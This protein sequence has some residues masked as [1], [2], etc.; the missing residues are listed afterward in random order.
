M[1]T[2]SIAD[3]NQPFWAKYLPSKIVSSWIRRYSAT[4]S[5]FPTISVSPLLS[6]WARKK[7]VLLRHIVTEDFQTAVIAEPV[8]NQLSDIR[9]CAE[10]LREKEV[11]GHI[12]C[13]IHH[14]TKDHEAHVELMTVSVKERYR[15]KGIGAVMIATAIDIAEKLSLP[16]KLDDMATAVPSFVYECR[17]E[18]KKNPVFEKIITYFNK[19][20]AEKNIYTSMGF[21]HAS[22]SF[23][24]QLPHPT[25]LNFKPML[26][27]VEAP[28]LAENRQPNFMSQKRRH[29]I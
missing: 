14:E 27:S 12:I 19:Q 21:S 4:P 17:D 6:D 10:S 29:S 3:L 15:G 24:S 13:R 9:I 26:K 2:L 18:D 7:G 20:S 8:F 25:I 11:V 1:P 22:G 28:T 23:A 5:T 16:I